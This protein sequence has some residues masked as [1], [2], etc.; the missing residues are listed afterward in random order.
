MERITI[1]LDATLVAEFE[2]FMANH[3]YRN[4]SEA[5]RDLIREKL[6]AERLDADDTAHCIGTLT[7][8]YNHHARELARR[9]TDTHHHHHDLAVSTLHVHLDHQNCLEAAVISGPTKQVRAFANTVI[10]EP[11]VRH[12]KLSLVPAEAR[13]ERHGH[14][15]NSHGHS[16]LH[17]HT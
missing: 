14:G 16:H 15:G 12:G 5:I 2:R 1:S 6:E 7:Y 4:R 10:S 11:G 8:V 3:N 17:P 13:D 9:L